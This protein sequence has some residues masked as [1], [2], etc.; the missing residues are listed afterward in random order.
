MTIK[1]LRAEMAPIALDLDA[2]AAHA[3]FDEFAPWV[4]RAMRRAAFLTALSDQAL[5]EC[6]NEIEYEEAHAS[7][8]PAVTR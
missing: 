6:Q 3:E 1:E 8:P 5:R 4:V 2:R 7:A